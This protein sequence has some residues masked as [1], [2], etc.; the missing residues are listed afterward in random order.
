MKVMRVRLNGPFTLTK[1]PFYLKRRPFS[2]LCPVKSRKW[3]SS[4]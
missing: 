3:K 1:A 2:S 4:R